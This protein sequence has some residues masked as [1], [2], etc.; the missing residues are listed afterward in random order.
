L[1]QRESVGIPKEN[2]RMTVK[3]RLMTTISI[4]INLLRWN[5]P[6]EEIRACVQAV[7]L[8]EFDGFELIY[9]E[10]HNPACASLVDKVREHFGADLRLRI[11]TTDSNLGYAGGHNRFFAETNTE[12][13]MVL[14]PDAI[15]HP[16]FLTRVVRTFSDARVG[17]VTG[18]MIKP[19][20]NSNG[21]SI[22][23]GTGIILS[24]SRRGRERGQL[25]VDRGQYDQQPRVF[26]VSGT[27]AVYRKSALEAVKLGESE[28]FDTD[29]FAYWEDLDL[30]WRLRLRGYEC[31]YV[32]DAIVE[33]GRAVGVSKGGIL[34]FRE[35]V[36]HHRSFSLQIRKWSWRNHLFAIIKNDCGWSLYRDLPLIV[37]RELA[38]IAFL[39]CFR[40]DTLS[41]VPE[42][43]RL[44]PSMLSKRRYIMKH[45]KSNSNASSL[46]PTLRPRLD[47]TIK[48]RGH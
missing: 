47:I 2:R 25:E 19:T 12:L 38:M 37:F 41:A 7:L 45:I 32:P 28:Y 3:P 29:F 11:V 14:N 39:I 20:Q 34:N 33:H 4:S 26:G 1:P 17:A 23:D 22:L 8:S 27:A 18:K 43:L 13:L 10:N 24:H 46:F 9:M 36:R 48:R 42:F 6:W 40:P 30:S 31:V 44:L 16:G 15:L 35:Y 5:S 21:E